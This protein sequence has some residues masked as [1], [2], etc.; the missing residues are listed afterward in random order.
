MS[1]HL[2]SIRSAIRKKKKISKQTT[3]YFASEICILGLKEA[4][5][6]VTDEHFLRIVI[7]LLA[8][9]QPISR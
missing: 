4:C 9:H 3:G 1:T 6:A 5:H 7:V 8:R 2:L